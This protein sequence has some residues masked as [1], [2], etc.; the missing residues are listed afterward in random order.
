MQDKQDVPKVSLLQQIIQQRDAF[1]QQ[2]AQLQ[3]QFQQIQG[4]VF[5]CNEMIGKIEQ[6]A[7]EQMEAIAKKSQGEKVDGEAHC[8]QTEQPA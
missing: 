5:A 4:A 8:E 3:V 7:R 2:S 1:I 6:D